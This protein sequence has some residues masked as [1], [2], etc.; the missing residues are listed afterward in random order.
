MADPAVSLAGRAAQ[1]S[2]GL[3]TL[4]E[5]CGHEE[6]SN[7]IANI[8]GELALLSTTL[9]RL[10]ESMAADSRAYTSAFDD[11]LKEITSELTLLFDEIEECCTEM[12]K[13]DAPNTTAVGWFFKRGR[14]S[15]LQKHLAA[16]KTT[17]VVM[18][19]VLYHGKDYGAMK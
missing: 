19:T 15:R 18:R 16:L 4:R 17:L 9:W 1:L 11:D 6:T 13:S 10:H 5:S 8:A 3:Y 14:V 12:H 7:D 2:T